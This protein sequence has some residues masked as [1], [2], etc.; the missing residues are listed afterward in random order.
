MNMAMR[1][2]Q[3]RVSSGQRITVSAGMT[4]KEAAMAEFDLDGDGKIDELE[5]AI[6]ECADSI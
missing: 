2:K 1:N 4:E 6:G 3:R 5:M